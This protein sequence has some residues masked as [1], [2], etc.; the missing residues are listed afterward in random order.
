MQ[1]GQIDTSSRVVVMA[2]IGNNHEGSAERAQELVRAA[3]ASGADAVK[4]QVFRTELFVDRRDERR[5][6]QLR[7]FELSR[8]ETE[9]LIELAR[10]LDV[11]VVATPLDLDSA[12]F[13]EPLVDAYKIASGDNLF[14]P[15]LDTVASTGKP[16]V[17][18]SGLSDLD[19]IER[20]VGYLRERLSAHGQQEQ[21]AVLHCVTSYPADPG[22]ANL[23]SIPYLREHLGCTVGWS[24]HMLGNEVAELAVAA[25][26]RIVE[27]HFT[28][29]HNTSAFRDHQLSAEPD[30]LRALVER[31][32]S[33]EATLGEERKTVQPA[34][35]PLRDPIGRSAVAAADLEPG[36]V[37][38]RDDIAWV[39]PAGGVSPED[40]GQLVGRRVREPIPAG[41]PLSL[42]DVEA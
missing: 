27:K 13:L 1:I 23:A 22:D 42:D 25:G 19:R 34:E 36:H 24:D 41:R 18:S 12:A 10:S 21:L 9:R 6:G 14:L 30:E 28:L 26:A 35:E 31:I 3:A 8:E 20:S 38:E 37:L 33:I 5:F 4:L 7:G 32:R 15:L 16:I 2:E 29:D 40:A 11:A 17:V 39:R